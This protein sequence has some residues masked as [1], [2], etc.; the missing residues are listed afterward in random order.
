[1]EQGLTRSLRMVAEWEGADPDEVEVKLNR[2]LIS[3]ALDANMFN[4]MVGAVQKGNISQETFYHNLQESGMTQPGVSFEEELK[5]I[6]ES[7]KHP[8][9]PAT[10]TQGNQGVDNAENV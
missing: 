9:L 3:S 8:E 1:M 4:A 10:E 6:E 2:E 7:F 5:R